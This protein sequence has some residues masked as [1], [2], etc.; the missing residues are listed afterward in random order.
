MTVQEFSNQF[1]ILYNAIA[2]QSA[3]GIDSYEKSVYLTKAQLEIIKNYY[4]PASN[5]KQ[6]GFEG[7]EKRRR[8]LKE[9]IVSYATNQAIEDDTTISINAKYYPIP[10]DVF[11]IVNE[12][13]KILSND[14]SNLKT[15]NVKPITL[16][17]FNIQEKNPFKKPD[18]TIAWRLDIS[19]V[20][21]TKVVEIVSPYN[22]T[23]SLEYK[24][25]YLKYP[26]PIILE[27]LN[28][29][30]PGEG[31]TIDGQFLPQTCELDSHIHEEILDRAVELCLRDYK[32]QNL[33]SKIQ[34]D[35]RNE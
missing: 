17:E 21:N 8:D 22:V 31:L 14:C 19:K 11:L 29:A 5:R 28:I 13:V 15:I 16:D 35:S 23:G 1:D 9:L 18:N 27:N 24:I 33:E 25:R 3:P 34:L 32:P 26:K 20:N 7:S 6:R 4:D 2:T 10:E 30:F 12:Q